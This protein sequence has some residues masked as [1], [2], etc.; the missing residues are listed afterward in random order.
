[1]QKSFPLDEVLSV[2]TGCLVAERHMDAI[3]DLCNHLS[4]ES[5][6]THQLVRGFKVGS[7]WLIECF[8]DLQRASDCVH[9]I[10]ERIAA[11]GDAKDVCREWVNEQRSYLPETFDIEP[12]P[13]GRWNSI[14]P[15]TEAIDMMGPDKVVAATT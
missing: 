6:F 12:L 1:M 15:I 11:G 10:E 9:Q 3:Y 7:P 2:S 14:D 8:P 4:G 13:P 5:L